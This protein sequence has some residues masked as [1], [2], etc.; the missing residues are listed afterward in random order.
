MMP[1]TMASMGKENLI[2]RIGGKEETKRYLES[3][4]FTVGG[5]VTVVNAI[6]GNM[7]VNVKN[8]R[9]AIGREMANRIMV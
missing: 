7:I 9:I 6:G 8:S 3:L 1:L 4:G 5:A 2:K